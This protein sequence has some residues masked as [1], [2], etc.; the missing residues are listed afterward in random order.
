LFG[1]KPRRYRD[2]QL[3]TSWP[4]GSSGDTLGQNPLG[5]LVDPA[6][7]NDIHLTWTTGSVLVPERNQQ[8]S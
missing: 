6:E 8:R 2:E 7:R 1:G 3:L 5:P 4:P